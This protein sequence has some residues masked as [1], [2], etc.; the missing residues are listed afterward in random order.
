MNYVHFSPSSFASRTTATVSCHW[1][2]AYRPRFHHFPIYP[3][4]L[5]FPRALFNFSSPG[6]AAVYAFSATKKCSTRFSLLIYVLA[7]FS[8]SLAAVFSCFHSY[9]AKVFFIVEHDRLHSAA[10][11]FPFECCFTFPLLFNEHLFIATEIGPWLLLASI[12]QDTAP[13]IL[14]HFGNVKW[15]P[16][17]CAYPLHSWLCFFPLICYLAPV[18]QH[19]SRGTQSSTFHSR[20][21]TLY[22]GPMDAS[23]SVGAP[24][25]YSQSGVR[26]LFVLGPP[27]PIGLF[28]QTRATIQFVR[29]DGGRFPF[30]EPKL[31]FELC[32][33]KTHREM[34]ELKSGSHFQWAHPVRLNSVQNLNFYA[35]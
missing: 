32:A 21:W 35:S 31:P 23:Q 3:V 14:S 8:Y 7:R 17:D 29:L 12:L 15:N 24:E 22:C 9:I 33:N 6:A 19:G 27:A 16:F 11:R 5:N 10:F 25:L 2:L 28:V 18:C 1:P 30:P 20:L 34:S 4:H 13:A 26:I